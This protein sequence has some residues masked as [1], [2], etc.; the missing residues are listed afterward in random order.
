MQHV[1]EH[2]RECL[3]C[4]K[5]GSSWRACRNRCVNLDTDFQNCG[6]CGRNCLAEPECRAKG[7]LC[8]AGR[9]TPNK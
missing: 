5:L 9:C 6:A 8:K 7:C 2:D 4:A 3:D 1:A